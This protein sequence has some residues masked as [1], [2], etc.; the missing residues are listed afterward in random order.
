MQD[1]RQRGGYGQPAILLAAPQSHFYG[2]R[3][4]P[5]GAT[6]EET[7]T[8]R[9]R[10]GRALHITIIVLLLL[11]LLGI[12]AAIIAAAIAASE[13]QDCHKGGHCKCDPSEDC[14]DLNPCTVDCICKSKH[15]ENV[16]C[17]NHPRPNGYACNSSCFYPEE[18]GSPHQCFN[19]GKGCA[20][21]RGSRCRGECNN[22][23]DCPRRH[24]RGPLLPV[25][26]RS[27][28]NDGICVWEFFEDFRI[29]NF[30]CDVE[31]LRRRCMRFVKPEFRDCIIAEPSCG[32]QFPPHGGKRED[33]PILPSK[34]TA[35]FLLPTRNGDGDAGPVLTRCAFSFKCARPS[36]PYIPLDAYQPDSITDTEEEGGEEEQPETKADTGL[37][38]LVGGKADKESDDLDI[39]DFKKLTKKYSKPHT[40]VH[41]N[42]NGHP[43]NTPTA[44]AHTIEGAAV[45]RV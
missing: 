40:T 8:G 28:C 7:D 45:K 23:Y 42:K 18:D 1:L 37:S 25:P 3:P 13:A 14:D 11:L 44:A 15:G 31:V 21:C 39:E 5:I 27:S 29:F 38:S 10:E 20:E 4:K 35:E 24:G 17:E 12:I 26:Q 9:H 30:P 6:T 33:L 32:I 2:Q 41:N 19:L 36:E 43:Q 34:D 22:N 16:P